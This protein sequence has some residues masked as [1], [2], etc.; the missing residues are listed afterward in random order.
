VKY[1]SPNDVLV[2]HALV[3]EETGGVHGIRDIGLLQSACVRPCQ[4]FGGK[5]VYPTIFQKVAALFESFVKY[6]VFIDG[7][8]RTAVVAVGRFLFLNG[9][10]LIVSNKELEKF[11]LQVASSNVPLEK[12]VRWVKKSIKKS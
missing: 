9:Y 1:L 12:I 4:V 5:A 11:T 10:E 6:H 7:N 3:I 2:L 8:K